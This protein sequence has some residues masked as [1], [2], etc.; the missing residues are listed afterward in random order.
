VSTRATKPVSVPP[1]SWPTTKGA[2]LSTG[3]S[4]TRRGN[5]RAP[6]IVNA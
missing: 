1:P 3:E 4:T 6:S 2:P 5:G